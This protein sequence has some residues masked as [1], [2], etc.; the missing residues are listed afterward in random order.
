MQDLEGIGSFLASRSPAVARRV[1]SKLEKRALT[2]SAFPPRA[3]VVPELEP[4]GIRD[5][6]ELIEPP[7]RIVFAVAGKRVNVMAVLD[8]R[9]DLQDELLLRLVRSG[10]R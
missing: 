10:T 8:G 2:L 7:Y 5:W 4:F 9:R 3:R 6:R 1:L